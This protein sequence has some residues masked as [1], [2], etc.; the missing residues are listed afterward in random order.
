MATKFSP[1]TWPDQG[2][3][4]SPENAAPRPLRSSTPICRYSG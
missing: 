1:T 3:D 4:F 2:F